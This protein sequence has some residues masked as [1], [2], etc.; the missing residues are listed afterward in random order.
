MN[1]PAPS[2]HNSTGTQRKQVLMACHVVKQT[3]GMHENKQAWAS[4]WPWWDTAHVKTVMSKLSCGSPGIQ[5]MCKQLSPCCLGLGLCLNI[6]TFQVSRSGC[7]M[8]ALRH[9]RHANGLTVA[10]CLV[11]LSHLS[12]RAWKV[13]KHVCLWEKSSN[14]GGSAP[15]TDS[16]CGRQVMG[17]S[18]H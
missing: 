5:V 16:P 2:L 11:R 4:R 8:A 7:H 17:D 12:A 1:R 3:L 15:L 14:E 13:Y 18:F 9:S 6:D 10:T